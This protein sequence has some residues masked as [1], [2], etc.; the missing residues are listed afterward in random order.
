[1][2]NNFHYLWMLLITTLMYLWYFVFQGIEFF[3]RCVY[4]QIFMSISLKLYPENIFVYI[5]MLQFDYVRQTKLFISKV[6]ILFSSQCLS[7]LKIY[8][9]FFHL[10]VFM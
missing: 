8:I 10:S 3:Y 2:M 1:M 6:F 9:T 5:N 4:Q 7:A